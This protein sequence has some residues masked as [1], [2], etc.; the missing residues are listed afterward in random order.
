MMEK[1][2]PVPKGASD[3]VKPSLFK[4]LHHLQRAHEGH[5]YLVDADGLGVP[6]KGVFYQLVALVAVIDIQLE[7]AITR[8]ELAILMDPLGIIAIDHP[9]DGGIDRKRCEL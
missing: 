9:M 8:I 4:R 7:G 3:P 2:M 1:G 6:I 5:R